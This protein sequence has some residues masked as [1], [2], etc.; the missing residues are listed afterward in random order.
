MYT[1]ANLTGLATVT[2][3]QRVTLKF[4]SN[5]L[6]NFGAGIFSSFLISIYFS[7]GQLTPVNW[8]WFG[9]LLAA[10]VGSLIAA[11]VLAHWAE[12]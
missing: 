1:Q 10:L 8:L 7:P 5:G 3:E 12:R 9:G 2:P 11:Y 6:L 4:M